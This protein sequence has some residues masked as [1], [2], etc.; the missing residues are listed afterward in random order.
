MI[1]ATIIL[2]IPQGTII[3]AS[4]AIFL[5]VIL[6]LVGLLL[7]AKSKLT[8]Q[9]QVTLSINADKQLDVEPGSSLLATLSNNGKIGRAHV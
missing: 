1:L 8:P 2:A 3:A 6:L 4:I 7:L 9:G 5:V